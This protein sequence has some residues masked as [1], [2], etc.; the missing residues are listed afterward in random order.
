MNAIKNFF[1]SFGLS[2]EKELED[3]L[4]DD[5]GEF[6]DQLDLINTNN[7]L[8]QIELFFKT[9]LPWQKRLGEISTL[10]AQV[11]NRR[12]EKA[13]KDELIESLKMFHGTMQAICK[14]TIGNSIVSS[15]DVSPEHILLHTGE[16]RISLSEL[17][18]KRKERKGHMNSELKNA[19]EEAKSFMAKNVALLQSS[20]KGIH[21]GLS[22]L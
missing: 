22:C 14:S 21:L 6:E 10:L 15:D 19:Q 18:Q 11:E 17:K 5:L 20:I 2:R 13:D 16:K 12:L 8:D 7:S 4:W 1:L 3:I 9:V